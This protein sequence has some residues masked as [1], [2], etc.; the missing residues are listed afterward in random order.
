[1]IESREAHNDSK[2]ARTIE[3]ARRAGRASSQLSYRFDRPSAEPLLWFP[4]AVAG[5]LAAHLADGDSS[6]LGQ[7][8]ARPWRSIP[9]TPDRAGARGP[10]ISG[11]Q[12]GRHFRR[13]NALD[14]SSLGGPWSSF[15]ALSAIRPRATIPRRLVDNI[16]SRL[17]ILAGRSGR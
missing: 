16:T 15:K 14:P 6:Y 17:V 10:V 3:Q 1:M 8:P 4:D 2:D 13:R 7:L 5:A 11:G 12:P 9:S